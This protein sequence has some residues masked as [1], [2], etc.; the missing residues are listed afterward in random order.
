LKLDHHDSTSD[1]G[2][3]SPYGS[4]ALI[5][6]ASFER[7]G[8]SVDYNGVIPVTTIYASD[9]LSPD[10][11]QIT[12]SVFGNSWAE[13]NIEQTAF[14]GTYEINAESNVDFGVSISKVSN[15]ESGTNVQ[16]NTWGQNAASAYGAIADLM[17]PASLAGVYDSIPGGGNITNNFFV[18]DM[19]DLATRAEFLQN[20]NPNNPIYLNTA[21]AEGDC[22]TGFCAD[23]NPGFGNQFIEETKAA[24]VQYTHIGEIGEM[25]YNLLVGL[26]YEETEVTSSAE[27]E[28]YV[29]V[30]WT[31]PNEFIAMAGDDLIPSGLK[32][33]YDM[34]LPNIDFDIELDYDVKLRA[35]YSKSL[36]R[37]SYSD[38]RG[39][40]TIGEYMRYENGEAVATGS[41]GNPG[42]L[43]YE[44]DNYD[45]SLEWYYDEGS[46]VSGGF[47]S[48]KVVNWISATRVED[49][50]LFEGLAH[51]A[52]GSLYQDAVT[53]LGGSPSNTDIRDYIFTNFANSAGVDVVAGTITGVAGRDADAYFDVNTSVNGDAEET[54]DGFE[55]AWQ[56]DFVGTGFGFIANAT[57]ASG[58]AEYDRLE[59]SVDN[60][61]LG[62]LSDTRNLIGYYDKDGIQVRVAYNWR[63][64]FYTGGN[65]I[66]AYTDEY[67]QW[68]I[69]AS[70]EYSK[71]LTV[72]F[73]GINITDEYNRSHARDF[74]Q[75]YFV[76]Q[77]GPRYNLGFRYTF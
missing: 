73:E 8:A 67:K 42:L 32:D 61:G 14:S 51:P 24:Y 70:Y 15:F 1:R 2:P 39:N 26:R 49:V 3:N 36:A 29:E 45:L 71:N 13:M 35:S 11:M 21:L 44:S 48:K 63:D 18:F 62:G 28:D 43:P 30:V 55:I 4:S 38:L 40:L 68:D 16:R 31:S 58:S 33:T 6:I 5:T 60:Y 37:A 75:N 66:P 53:A 10:D 23:S 47:F 25:P 19:A 65:L 54:I 72:F 69:T 76:G 34:F 7:Q 52:L 20:L 74:K 57:F 22:G 56:H 27:S 9:P 46:Y 50:V 17:T 59:S 41:V 64:T 12:G 77:T